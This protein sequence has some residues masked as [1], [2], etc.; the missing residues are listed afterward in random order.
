[1]VESENKSSKSNSFT[2]SGLNVSFTWSG[3][4]LIGILLFGSLYTTLSRSDAHAWEDVNRSD[5]IGYYSYLPATVIYHDLSYHFIDSLSD[6]Y[7]NL[8]YSKYLGFCNSFNNKNVNKYFVGESILISPFFLVAHWSSGSK[9]NPA[10]GFS[11]FY[12]LAICLAALFYCLLGLWSIRNLLKRFA[13][14]DGIVAITLLC[15]FFG[16]NLFYYTIWDPEMS[17]VYSFGLISLFCLQLHK[18]LEHFSGKRFIL[19]AAL[20]ALIILVRPINALIV[21]A[22]PFLSGN[23]QV[24]KTFFVE[25]FRKKIFL[26]LA[27][28]AFLLVLFIQ[29]LY[30]HLQAET[31]LV[32]AYEKEGF[33]FTQPHFFSCLF[34][35]SNGFYVYTP[36]LFVGTFGLF[37]FLP[38]NKFRFVSL[39]LFF[40]IL[41]FVISSWWKW[42][43]AG[44]LGMRPLVEYYVL[45]A[46]LFGLLLE[47]ISR[48]R[49]AFMAI[50]IL[51]LLPLT[52]L[53]QLQIWQYNRGIIGFCDMT[54][55]KYW[56]VFLET[57]IQFYWIN[58]TNPPDPLPEKIKLL[59]TKSIDFENPDSSYDHRSVISGKAF[60][61]KHCLCLKSGSNFSPMIKIRLGDYFP[62]SICRSGKLWVN[63]SSKWMLEDNGSESSL[64]VLVGNFIDYK[65]HST[66]F[67]IHQVREE[68]KWG[69]CLLNV[70]LPPLEADDTLRFYPKRN[71][72]FPVYVDDL[73]MNIFLEEK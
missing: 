40:T 41:I 44:A 9:E 59:Y 45:F 1:M 4:T 29:L 39:I 20:L 52:V 62:D 17:H 73:K 12:L 6:K 15:V 11:F 2:W 21:L 42:T 49:L 10:D 31:W 61:G 66:E 72:W 56:M 53:C 32:Y 68:N 26:L 3:L 48:K 55:E 22:L 60:S 71:L 13:I 24:L 69:N 58:S 38:K 33:D 63:G 28:L 19:L 14:K 64:N 47:K 34:S 54:K 70:N 8:E 51:V 36:I 65:L 5:G 37:T 27:I 7:H 35:Y 25:C 50:S 16:T 30:Y 18:Q 46:L 67:V 43:Y 23:R 57:R